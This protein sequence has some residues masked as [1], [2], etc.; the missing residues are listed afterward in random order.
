MGLDPDILGKTRIKGIVGRI[1]K[2]GLRGIAFSEGY[3]WVDKDAPA[4]ESH[5][6]SQRLSRLEHELAYAKQE[7]EFIKKI[8]LANRE[9]KRKCSSKQDRT[10]SSE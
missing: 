5:P 10:P 3:H 7:L 6:V 2:Q 4:D 8:I 9:G 1:K